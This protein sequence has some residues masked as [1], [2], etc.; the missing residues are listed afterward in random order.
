MSVYIYTHFP[1]LLIVYKNW[2]TVY[3]Y[4]YLKLWS[5]RNVTKL[6]DQFVDNKVLVVLVIL[7]GD[8]QVFQYRMPTEFNVR[9]V[10]HTFT[11]SKE[12]SEF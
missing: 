8:E 3:L 2:S 9:K 4:I 6:V 1:F 5:V 11:R 10:T 7:A 12:E